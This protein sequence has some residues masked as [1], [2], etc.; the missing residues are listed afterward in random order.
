MV[1]GY[2]V[3]IQKIETGF[4]AYSPDI[5][6]CVATG[7]SREEVEANMKAA[8]E[9]HIEGLHEEGLEIPKPTSSSTHIRFAA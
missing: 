7:A 4:S 1:Q 9:F 6:G 8:L 2:L 3:I 5:L